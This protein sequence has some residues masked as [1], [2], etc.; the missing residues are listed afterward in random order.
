MVVR[1]NNQA[2]SAAVVEQPQQQF[3]YVVPQGANVWNQQWAQHTPHTPLVTTNNHQVNAQGS[4]NYAANV[5]ATTVNAGQWPQVVTINGQQYYVVVDQPAAAQPTPVVNQVVTTRNQVAGG[6]QANVAVDQRWTVASGPQGQGQY[7]AVVTNANGDTVVTN[8]PVPQPQGLPAVNFDNL[9]PGKPL[10]CN[11][12]QHQQHS[13]FKGNVRRLEEPLD[14]PVYNDGHN[15]NDSFDEPSDPAP[16]APVAAPVV[17]PVRPQVW[18]Q[19]WNRGFQV[20]ND[21]VSKVNVAS[22]T[23]DEQQQEEQQQE[24]R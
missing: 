22:V 17:A 20:R 21:Q 16:V 9:R 24:V 10:A 1:A 5:G 13:S 6:T 2:P 3:Y 15:E 4:L 11:N 18:T 23:R 12:I 19:S 7:Y 14:T 8:E